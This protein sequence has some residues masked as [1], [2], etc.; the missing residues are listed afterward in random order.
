MTVLRLTT[1]LALV[2]FGYVL[3][4]LS[5][6][7]YEQSARENLFGADNQQ[8]RPELIVDC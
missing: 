5:I 6:R 1:P 8:E 2:K 4:T 3:E 7:Q